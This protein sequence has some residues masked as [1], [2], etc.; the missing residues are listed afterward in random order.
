MPRFV[1]ERDL[2][3]AG[4]MSPAELK[5][6]SQKS[7]GIMRDLGP[8]IQWDHSYVTDDKIFCVY[9]ADD[10]DAIKEHARMAGLPVDSI[11]RV[12]TVIDPTTAEG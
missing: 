7:V 11:H 9:M 2:P 4:K 1:I 10:P 12:G 8:D 5:A 3:G 6:L